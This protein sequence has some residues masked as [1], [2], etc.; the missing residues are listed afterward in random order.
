MATTNPGGR[1]RRAPGGG[2]RGSKRALLVAINDYG[3][4]QNNLP[5][6]LEDA[7][8]FRSV[9]QSRYGFETFAELYDGDATVANVDGGLAWLFDNVAEDDRLVFFYSGH[10]YQQSRNGNLDECLV[11]GNLEFFFDDRLSELSQS[12]PP[13]VLT[14]V[15]DSCFSGGMQKPIAL[16]GGVEIAR[17]KLWV[18]PP[19]TSAAKSLVGGP[20]VPRPFGCFP[21][22]DPATVKRLVLGTQAGPNLKAD[23]PQAAGRDEASQLQLNGLLLSACS[24]NETASAATSATE[25]LSAFTYAMMRTLPASGEI[26]VTQLH[27]AAREQLAQMGFRQTPL[28]KVPERPAELASSSFVTLAPAAAAA[29]QP[30]KTLPAEAG[31]EPTTVEPT[32]DVT[33]TDQQA[34][35]QQFW[36]TVERVSAQVAMAAGNQA[37]AERKSFAPTTR[38]ATPLPANGPEGQPAGPTTGPAYPAENPPQAGAPSPTGPASGS[39][40]G[41]TRP[42]PRPAAPAASEPTDAG[43]PAGEEKWVRTALTI[44]GMVAP[45]VI[46]AFRKRPKDFAPDQDGERL[47]ESVSEVVAPAIVDAIASQPESADGAGA[48]K[49][50]GAVARVVASAV[51]SIVAEFTRKDADPAAGEQKGAIAAAVIGAAAWHAIAAWRGKSA[52][53]SG[54]ATGEDGELS[55][56][57]TRIAAEVVPAVVRELAGQNE[58]TGQKMILPAGMQPQ[59]PGRYYIM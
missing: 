27:A 43:A 29:G 39:N 21:V 34:Y 40:G 10:G 14:V 32:E 13:G 5:S 42:A 16:G 38:P 52:G 33:V 54:D 53:G 57:A 30:A 51:P 50:W 3:S 41:A 25:G 8:Q 23:G 22:T 18:P 49:F 20:L 4:P 48:D 17:T 31:G 24:E 19:D 58:P 15:L 28:L 59:V 6:C 36:R 44:A 56:A 11:L 1:A 12:A 2:A 26:S 45:A 9:L 37:S 46:D 47:A 35:D 7:A 55:R